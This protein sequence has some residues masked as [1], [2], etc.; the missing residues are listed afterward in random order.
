MLLIPEFT[1]P[2]V[3]PAGP[4]IFYAAMF[5]PGTLSLETLVSDV[6]MWEFFL[7]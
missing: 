7:E 4:F 1:T 2:A 6:A 3:S 5:E